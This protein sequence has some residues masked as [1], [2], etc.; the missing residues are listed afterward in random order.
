MTLVYDV[1]NV[2]GNRY[3]GAVVTDRYGRVAP[4]PAHGTE[5]LAFYTSSGA[6]ILDAVT[7]LFERI[8]NKKLTVRKIYVVAEKVLDEK[9][10]SEREQSA[11]EQL[12]MF[13]GT[14]INE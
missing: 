9:D 10:A 8:C 1:E 7:R 2:S 5:N 14:E 13:L 11:P 4:K 12:D 3:A 6:I